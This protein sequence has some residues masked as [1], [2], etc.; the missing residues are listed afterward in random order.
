MYVYTDLPPPSTVAAG[1]VKNFFNE[2]KLLPYFPF[3]AYG[4]KQSFSTRFFS[5]RKINFSLFREN[6]FLKEK[7]MWGERA[8]PFFS[9]LGQMPDSLCGDFFR[10]SYTTY[11]GKDRKEGGKNRCQQFPASGKG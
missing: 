4:E 11:A 2:E 7:K 3:F 9:L 5:G 10:R 1:A 8:P 6:G